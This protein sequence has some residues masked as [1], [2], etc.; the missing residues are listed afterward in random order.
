MTDITPQDITA[1]DLRGREDVIVTGREIDFAPPCPAIKSIKPHIG[2]PAM[3]VII[4]RQVFSREEE[5]V[6]VTTHAAG[7]GAAIIGVICLLVW[8]VETG[9]IAVTGAA[10]Y[11]LTL[12]AVYGCST[13]YH[14]SRDL[15]RR[16]LMQT[17][18]HCAI[19]LLIGGSY[20]PFA[21]QGIGGWAGIGLFVLMWTM[22]VA[23]IWMR[24]WRPD[25]SA[26]FQTWLFLAMGWCGVL[27]GPAMFSALPSESLYLLLACGVT[28]TGG[29][30]FYLWES[31]PHNHGIWHLFVMG[32]SIMHFF[33]VAAL[34]G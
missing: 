20:T 21:L 7:F 10:I 30:V 2:L 11:G 27:W 12:L 9:W 17:L 25:L 18:D 34:M 13:V 24:L 16:R 19:F 14:A 29:V 23:G 26:R 15:I 22:A 33:S 28:Y 4:G 8:A 3:N 32:G 5:M 31:L 1:G 6:N